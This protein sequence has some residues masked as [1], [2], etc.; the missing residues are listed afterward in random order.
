[1]APRT[2]QPRGGEGRAGEGGGRREGGEGRKG[3]K[4]KEGQGARGERGR[5][6]GAESVRL[7]KGWYAHS[8]R[9]GDYVC[10][11]NRRIRRLWCHQLKRRTIDRMEGFELDPTG[12]M[13]RGMGRGRNQ[14][15]D[16]E[17]W[18]AIWQD[19]IPKL[20]GGGGG[21]RKDRKEERP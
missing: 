13:G 20:S 17:P 19:K 16:Q 8:Y 12:C 5:G 1:M 10:C 15:Q 21:D 4:V 9:A 14:G 2:R 6:A 11:S 3:E 7:S 18:E